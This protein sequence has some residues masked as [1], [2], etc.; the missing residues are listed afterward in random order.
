MR[1]LLASCLLIFSCSKKEQTSSASN[2]I[3]GARLKISKIEARVVV[4]PKRK[5]IFKLQK[6][7]AAMYAQFIICTV[8]KP[9]R[10][11]PSEKAPG[12]APTDDYEFLT[13]PQGDLEIKA[14]ACVE[15]PYALNPEKLCG[16]WKRASIG[17]PTFM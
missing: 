2:K 12:M 11:L 13:P 1:I 14:R 9:V 4:D 17:T 3:D 8:T 5:V 7:P 10:C 6:D 16:D 15:V